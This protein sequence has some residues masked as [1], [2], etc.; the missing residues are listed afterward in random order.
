MSA[1]YV[2]AID[3]ETYDALARTLAIPKSPKDC[4]LS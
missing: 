4:F 1:R 2:R 3:Y